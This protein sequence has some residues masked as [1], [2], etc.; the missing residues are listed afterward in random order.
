MYRLLIRLGRVSVIAAALLSG[1]VLSAPAEEPAST[2]QT[3]QQAASAPAA[4]AEQPAAASDEE[5]N[6]GPTGESGGPSAAEGASGESQGAGSAEGTTSA[7][8][9]EQPKQPAGGAAEEA[10]PAPAGESGGPSAAEGASGESQGAGSAE[11]TTSAAPAEQPQAESQPESAPL[12]AIIAEVKVVGNERIPT[13]EILKAIS[14]KVGAPYSS[15]QV[16]RDREKVVNLGWFQTVAVDEESVESGIRLTFRVVENPVVTAIHITGNRELTTKEILSLMKTKPGEVFNWPRW[17]QDGAAIE[18]EYRKRGFVL[19]TVLPPKMTN[20]GVL[21]VSIAE[22]I[23]Q[24]V[25]ITGNTHTKEYVIRRYIRTKPGET[26]NEKK[27]AADVQR[28]NNLG[29]F[30]TVRRYA[31]AGEAGKVVV[32]ITVVEKRYTGGASFGGMYGSDYGMVAFVDVSKTNLWG[33][34]QT[35]AVKGE[36]GGRRTYELAYRNPWIMSPETRLNLGLYDRRTVREA[37][38]RPEDAGSQSILYEERRSGGNMTLGRPLSDYTTAYLS[39]R[40]DNISVTDV[41]EW[42]RQY[43]SGP[44]FEPRKI[45]SITVAGVTETRDNKFNPKRGGYRSLSAEFAGFGGADFTKYSMDLRHYWPVKKKNVF[46][47][48]LLAGTVTSDAPYLEQFLIGGSE[49]LRGYRLDRFAGSHMAILNTEYRF[50]LTKN[51]LGVLFVDAGDAWGGEIAADPYVGGDEDFSIH[52]GY[53][54]GIRVKTPIGPIRLDLGFSEDGSET[55]FG[56]SNMF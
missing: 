37:F 50:P 19:A 33:T 49:S 46:A 11:G 1:V 44:A 13:E 22:G 6:Q 17:R 51:L 54:V 47:M 14:S 31:E 12:P 8:P 20:D 55:H 43:L 25:K 36:F 53:G 35:V 39:F 40:S 4:P 29:Y 38:V 26:Y 45:R 9:A 15:D 42:E 16:K 32:V 28:L 30:E 41:D 3:D 23:V 2:P 34:G 21:S 52:T 24:E 7:A 27:V 10:N 48:R 5:T 18:K 56:V